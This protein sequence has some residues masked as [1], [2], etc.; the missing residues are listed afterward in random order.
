MATTVYKL[1]IYESGSNSHTTARENTCEIIIV[2]ECSTNLEAVKLMK[3]KTRHSV[4]FLRYTV[5]F[6]NDKRDEFL[7][8]FVDEWHTEYDKYLVNRIYFVGYPP[9]DKIKELLL[10]DHINVID[11]RK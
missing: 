10:N 6:T 4:E 2:K 3:Q 7:E 8:E 11:S 1:W 5:G 9:I